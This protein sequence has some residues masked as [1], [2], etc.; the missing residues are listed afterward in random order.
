M[1]LGFIHQH[2]D[3]SL[4]QAEVPPMQQD[5][6]SMLPGHW[7]EAHATVTD[8]P[9]ITQLVGSSGEGEVLLDQPQAF[10][11]SKRTT[12]RGRRSEVEYLVSFP[13]WPGEDTW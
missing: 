10:I 1:A 8:Y 9:S 13:A 5:A 4:H 11:K 2:I 3:C 7:S 12:K 6:C